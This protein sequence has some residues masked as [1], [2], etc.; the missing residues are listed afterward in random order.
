MEQ[1]S[2]ASSFTATH[3]R[4]TPLAA[5]PHPLTPMDQQEV[6]AIYNGFGDRDRIHT[7]L[8]GAWREGASSLAKNVHYDFLRTIAMSRRHPAQPHLLASVHGTVNQ[9]LTIG[10]LHAAIAEDP[11]VLILLE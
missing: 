7:V 6:L 9:A 8:L 11:G 1:G 3:L 2:E 5:A 10:D 4:W